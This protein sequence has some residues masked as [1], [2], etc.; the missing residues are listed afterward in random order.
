M[1][2][3]LEDLKAVRT[4]LTPPA[5]WT[6]DYYAM[7]EEQSQIEPWSTYATCYCMLGAMNKVVAE[8][9]FPNQLDELTYDTSEKNPR[10][11]ALEGAIQIV[12]T[13]THSDIPTFND[14]RRTTH[15]DVLNVL[16]EA[17]ANVKSAS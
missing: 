3:L 5:K 6:R 7:D 10:W 2:Q 1:S 17:I 16:D 4:L 9:E 8:G 12:V 13:R 14:D 11:K 15:D